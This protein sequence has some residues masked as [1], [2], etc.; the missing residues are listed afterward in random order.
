[1]NYVSTLNTTEGI[2]QTLASISAMGT[3]IYK[4]LQK[5][6]VPLRPKVFFIE[7]QLGSKTAD[8]YIAKVN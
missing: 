8:D 7:D 3:F 6:K 2:M 1:M 4:G 5:R